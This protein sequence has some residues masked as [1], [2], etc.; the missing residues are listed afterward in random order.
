LDCPLADCV[1]FNGMSFSVDDGWHPFVQAAL[2]HIE[3]GTRQY[4]GSRLEKFYA[5][6]KPRNAREALLAEL[7]GPKVLDEHA[8]YVKHMPWSH[9]TVEESEAFMARVIEIENTAFGDRT[10]A[11]ESGYGLQGPVSKEKGGL[12]YKR[13]IGVLTSIRTK[14]YDRSRGDIT[15][16]VLHRA[17]Q[18][19]YVIKHGHH[20]AAA[21]AALGHRSIPAIPVALVE[22]GEVD[23]WRGVYTRVWSRDEALSYFDHLFDFDS[24]H[25]ARVHGLR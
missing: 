16:E 20:R 8:P 4:E 12:E 21:M 2:E 1:E 10:L 22:P 18:F 13:L 7:S 15:V 17:G 25:W 6:W 11:A 3:K 24:L 14:G 9:R 23:H 19:R 5:S